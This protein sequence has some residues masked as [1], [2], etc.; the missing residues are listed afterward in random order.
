[1]QAKAVRPDG[2]Q[3]LQASIIQQSTGFLATKAAGSHVDQ[4]EHYKECRLTCKFA[5]A[6]G[7]TLTA[8][9]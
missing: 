7:K 1:M 5:A 3:T 9:L 2:A 6:Q 4:R 8:P